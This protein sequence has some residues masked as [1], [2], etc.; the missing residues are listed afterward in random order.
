LGK[1]KAALEGI[2]GKI[3]PQSGRLLNYDELM[4]GA[5]ETWNDEMAG[6]D[7]AE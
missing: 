2:G 3:D 4:D 6:W 5:V 1:D 7:A